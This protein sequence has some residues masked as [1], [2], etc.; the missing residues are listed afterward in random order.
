MKKKAQRESFLKRLFSPPFV[1]LTIVAILAAALFGTYAYVYSGRNAYIYVQDKPIY[2]YEMSNAIIE[3]AYK[4]NV[5]LGSIE[6]GNPKSAFV[7][8][9]LNKLAEREVISDKLLYLMGLKDNY[10]CSPAEL[11]KS[12][13]EFKKTV[14]GISNDPE[15]NFES[16]LELRNITVRQLKQILKEKVIVNKETDKLTRN[17]TVTPKEVRDYYKEWSFAYSEKGKT[18]DEIFRE[19]YDKIK[20]DTLYSKKQQYMNKFITKLINENKDKIVID[21]RYKKFMRWIYSRVLNLAVPD[22][23]KP[24]KL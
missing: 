13:Y 7:K 11:D 8:Y 15:K 12:M 3:Q 24:G 18:D 21:N 19:K 1:V 6:Q 16:E 10:S 2:N 5:N 20:D 22:E 17:I 9:T 23:F 4:N 14:T